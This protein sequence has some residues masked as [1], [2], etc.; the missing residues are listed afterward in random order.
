MRNAD[1]SK[2]K[3]LDADLPDMT[4]TRPVFRRSSSK[5]EDVEPV[6]SIIESRGRYGPKETVLKSLQSINEQGIQRA[7]DVSLPYYGTLTFAGVIVASLVS[8]FLPVVG[9]LV[10][11]LSGLTYAGLSVVTPF[12]IY[13]DCKAADRYLDQNW[14]GGKFLAA[15]SIFVTAFMLP[16]YLY[17]R[18][19][20]MP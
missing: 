7:G 19:K 20:K 6:R 15:L 9:G 10:S 13:W 5:D 2:F 12:I 11:T 16:F 4:D 18:I 14:I 17:Y 8:G 1:K 3:R